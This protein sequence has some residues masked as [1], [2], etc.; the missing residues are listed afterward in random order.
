MPSTVWVST[1]TSDAARERCSLGDSA[2]DARS[3]CSAWLPKSQKCAGR[4]RCACWRPGLSTRRRARHPAGPLATSSP[5]S[6][7]TRRRHRCS[8]E[9]CGPSGGHGCGCVV[10]LRQGRLLTLTEV[11]AAADGSAGSLS[12]L[13]LDGDPA[14]A[15]R[16]L[17][18][19]GR[20]ELA[21][22]VAS[23]L[24]T[25]SLRHVPLAGG[26]PPVPVVTGHGRPGTRPAR[27]LVLRGWGRALNRPFVDAWAQDENGWVRP[28]SGGTA[29]TWLPVDADRFAA[30]LAAV[31][32]EPPWP[33]GLSREGNPD[34]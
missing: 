5:T 2:A 29:S 11:A 6:S 13:L 25:L 4:G 12:T 18:P 19:V 1:T 23:A 9:G 8:A 33:Q 30:D 16:A 22:T 28:G 3:G 15:P 31:L 24:P 7:A 21:G 14:V 17:R 26:I 32:T 27:T 34:E 20:V 10:V